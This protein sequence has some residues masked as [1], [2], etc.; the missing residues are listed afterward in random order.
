MLRPILLTALIAGALASVVLSSAVL[1]KLEPLIR[2]AE[3]FEVPGAV[4][5]EAHAGG[6]AANIWS[7][8]GTTRIILTL[9]ASTI[10]S[11]GFALVLTTAVAIRGGSA[12]RYGWLWGLAGFA[13]FTL[14]PALGLPPQ[15]P[16]VVEADLTARQTW[17]IGTA[18]VTAVGLALLAF[19]PR[20]WK[21]GGVLLIG[22]PHL[23]GPPR[24]D[25]RTSLVPSDLATTF[26]LYSLGT[27]LVFWCVLG[28][29]I[30]WFYTR[31]NAERHPT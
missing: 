23:V 22:A 24:P 6:S 25:G 26:A 10:A 3:V 14:A 4:S 15:P 31:F 12:V 28:T 16:G 11:I 19:G 5:H 21:G 20:L 27:M 2:I 18:A 9:L 8:E 1:L 13:V 30:C 7:P 29:L 17:W